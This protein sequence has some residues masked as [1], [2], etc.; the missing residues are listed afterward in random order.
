MMPPLNPQAGTD[1]TR[2]RGQLGTGRR[3]ARG[4]AGTRR[5]LAPGSARRGRLAVVRVVGPVPAQLL[6]APAQV[7]LPAAEELL[8]LLCPLPVEPGQ[9]LGVVVGRQRPGPA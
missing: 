2:G 6:L 1:A 5:R 7:L 8:V 3:P 9:E 4:Q